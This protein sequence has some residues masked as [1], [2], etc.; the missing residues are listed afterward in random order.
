MS[1]NIAA[2]GELTDRAV[3]LEVWS[4][5]CNRSD[6]SVVSSYVSRGR[7][8]AAYVRPAE[9]AARG[10]HLSRAEIVT[11]DLNGVHQFGEAMEVKFWIR[12]DVPMAKACFSFQIIN[13][14][15]QPAV[16]SWALYPDIRFGNDSGETLL[17]CHLPSVRL[18]IG[19]FYLRANLSET[20]R[21]RSLQDWTGGICPFE[22]IQTKQATQWG[23]HPSDCSY[24]EEWQWK[25]GDYHGGNSQSGS[26][27]CL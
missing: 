16:H 9:N 23:W 8:A 18:N 15:Q 22:I 4:H 21:R 24:R 6:T 13:Q 12:H 3:L 7:T 26:M 5:N 27:K 11:S 1:H 20:A 10:P 17:I 19:Q 14:F 2:I 25:L